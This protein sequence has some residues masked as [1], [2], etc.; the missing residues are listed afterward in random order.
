[1]FSG[2]H[3]G[4]LGQRCDSGSYPA[5]PGTFL[6]YEGLFLQTSIFSSFFLMLHLPF[7]G[8]SGPGLMEHKG[9]H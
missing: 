5:K 6:W 7:Q 4:G 8:G 9:L 1:M 3:G 2:E